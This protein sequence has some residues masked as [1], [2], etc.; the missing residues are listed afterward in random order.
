MLLQVSFTP[1]GGSYSNGFRQL[2]VDMLQ[3]DPEVRPSANHLYLVRVPELIAMETEEEEEPVEE[4]PDV[5][6][7]K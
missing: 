7:T 1:I 6:K 5:T 4:P 2:V 3:K